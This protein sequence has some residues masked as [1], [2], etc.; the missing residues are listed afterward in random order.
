MSVCIGYDGRENNG[1]IQFLS[2][3]Y[4]DTFK[5]DAI[6]FISKFPYF[7]VF[8]LQLHRC[9]DRWL[10]SNILDSFKSLECVFFYKCQ[11]EIHLLIFFVSLFWFIFILYVSLNYV[12]FVVVVVVSELAKTSYTFQKWII[13]KF[14]F[15]LNYDY[16]LSPMGP[17]SIQYKFKFMNISFF[18]LFFYNNIIAP[19]RALFPF[20]L[21]LFSYKCMCVWLLFIFFT[22]L[23]FHC[24]S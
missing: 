5:L 24:C 19:T 17:Y 6:F 9:R 23:N 4:F 10:L 3:L 20:T 21:T 16:L 2:I 8:L 18:Y 22:I 12:D 14:S 1:F 11:R 13:C 15:Q 7:W